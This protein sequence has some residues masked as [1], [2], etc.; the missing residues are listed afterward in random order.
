MTDNS[1]VEIR[2]VPT[3]YIFI[4]GKRLPQPLEDA[5]APVESPPPPR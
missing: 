4:D 2:E 3:R 5:P 1:K